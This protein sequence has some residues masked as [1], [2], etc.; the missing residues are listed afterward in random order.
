MKKIDIYLACPYSHPS[1]Y[2]RRKRF[3]AANRA[4]GKLMSEGYIVYSPISHSHPIAVDC[5]LALEWKEWE[6]IDT[7]FISMSKKVVVLRVDGYQD[8]VGVG[9]EIEIARSISIQVEYMD[10]V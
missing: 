8:S 3:K 5:D 6:K 4:A 1:E 9:N 7:A 2:V 10:E